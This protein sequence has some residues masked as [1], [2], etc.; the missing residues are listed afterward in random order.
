MSIRSPTARGGWMARR[1]F[2]AVL[3]GS[4]DARLVSTAAVAMFRVSF[5][6]PHLP[7]ARAYIVVILIVI[8]Q[9]GNARWH[10]NLNELH[11]YL[12]TWIWRMDYDVCEP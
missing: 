8:A 1:P 7:T 10:F 9:R 12:S 11:E 6:T 4:L 3:H 2:P 5:C